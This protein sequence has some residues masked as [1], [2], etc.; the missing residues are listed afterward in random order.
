M[1]I[2]FTCQNLGHLGLDFT[3]PGL[4]HYSAIGTSWV[5][6]FH[7]TVCRKGR[8]GHMHSWDCRNQIRIPFWCQT[9]PR[10]QSSR[11]HGVCLPPQPDWVIP[12]S[13]TLLACGAC[14]HSPCLACAL[15]PPSL[16]RSWIPGCSSCT[17][18]WSDD[19]V[20]GWPWVESVSVRRPSFSP[21]P[22]RLR[23]LSLLTV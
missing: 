17:Y 4:W 19:S 23:T 9:N 11:I 2:P 18:F 21:S 8:K 3:A 10:T 22:S 13:H 12:E 15:R 6:G 14:F 20:A 7:G 1:R 5:A 16:P